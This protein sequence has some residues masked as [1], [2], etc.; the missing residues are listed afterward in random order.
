MARN[1]VFNP[2]ASGSAVV[3]GHRVG[4]PKRAKTAGKRAKRGKRNS[5]PVVSV[6]VA[7][8]AS[9]GTGSMVAAS[10]PRKRAKKAKK[11]GKRNSAPVVTVPNSPRKKSRKKSSG[12]KNSAHVTADV[13]KAI[14]ADGTVKGR[15]LTAK[16]RR[17][18]GWIAGGSKPRKSTKSRA[19]SARR[20]TAAASASARTTRTATTG[21][22]KSMAKKKR[23]KAGRRK[24]A[25][26]K[27]GS[28]K[29]GRRAAS[30]RSKRKGAAKTRKASKRKAKSKKRKTRRNDL[31]AAA[32]NPK[33]KRKGKRKSKAR[34]ASKRKAKRRTTKRKARRND[35]VAA[36][37]NPKRK[38]K[39]RK[40][41]ARK[42]GKARRGK[43]RAARRNDDRLT[44]SQA[45]ALIKKLAPKY[46]A[47]S[48]AAEK[49]KAA[50]SAKH[51]AL[52]A[53]AKKLGVAAP[54]ADTP[55]RMVNELTSLLQDPGND[56]KISKSEIKKLLAGI[57]KPAAALDMTG[58]MSKLAGA[59]DKLATK[60]NGGKRKSKRRKSKSRSRKSR[61]VAANPRKA[62]RKKSR[63]SS[64][65]GV[66]RS[67]VLA[68]IKAGGKKR[69]SRKG[70]RKASKSKRKGS[71][72]A[73]R[74]GKGR[75][76]SK[77]KTRRNAGLDMIRSVPVVGGP[78]ASYLDE[79]KE[80]G[81]NYLPGGA[82]GLVGAFG[83]PSLA[84]GLLPPKFAYLN[85]GWYGVLTS[86]VGVG[87]SSAVTAFV[88]AKVGGGSQARSQAIG[89]VLGGS[90]GVL[91]RAVSALTAPSSPIRRA[92]GTD[93]GRMADYSGLND[94]VVMA[95]NYLGDMPRITNADSHLVDLDY[96]QAGDQIGRSA[97]EGISGIYE[98]K[99]LLPQSMSDFA[100]PAEMSDFAAPY[101]GQYAAPGSRDDTLQ[102]AGTVPVTDFAMADGTD[103]MG[104][105]DVDDGVGLSDMVEVAGPQSWHQGR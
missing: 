83:L 82:A 39:A 47:A 103:E 41:K 56:F 19:R 23:S 76:H 6:D 62:K 49:R 13:A 88:A 40:S 97:D 53:L 55:D 42:G 74:R 11:S 105:S 28:R 26:K 16:Q 8:M 66:S 10:N 85:S 33:K 79:L 46:E 80:V 5:A 101:M 27:K 91:T 45:A 89:A 21:Q 12:G 81:V 36:A 75:K 59:I 72:K 2:R 96:G 38:R 63:K 29:A 60:A 31:V 44:E 95:P 25:P 51:A 67:E 34:K 87:I 98:V 61:R 18:F 57:P 73:A 102:L 71:R 92:I 48:S 65:K 43:R 22:R 58:V 90:L 84:V 77:R 15:K 3:S 52:A 86:A 70:K 100:A 54:V 7:T 32:A 94:D 30:K 24:A 20:G 50:D 37:A 99:D 64:R 93:A 35:L 4:K 69:K 17:Y 1:I 68:L 14:L 9:S 78:V 104:L